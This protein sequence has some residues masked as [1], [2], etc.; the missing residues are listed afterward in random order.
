LLWGVLY[1][2]LAAG[3]IWAF[4][5]RAWFRKDA[6][7]VTSLAV[8]AAFC[9]GYAGLLQGAPLE[10]TGARE[11]LFWLAAGGALIA[12]LERLTRRDPFFVRALFVGV[13]LKFVLERQ[14]VN[15][16]QGANDSGHFPGLALAV[17]IGISGWYAVER[18]ARKSPGV[19]A[20]LTL[21]CLATGLALCSLWSSSG[22]YAQLAGT[23]AA[24]MGAACVL[25][26]L[27]PGTWFAGGGAGLAWA[28]LFGIGL[29]AHYY[30]QLSA[31]DALLLA[32]APFAGLLA[33][34][35]GL[36]Q[37]RPQRR[38]LLRT[39]LVLIP[40]AIACAR[41]HAVYAGLGAED[42]GSPESYGY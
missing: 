38:V 19:G 13:L 30:S 9:I 31:A 17:A 39:V 15:H 36:R 26:W 18:V 24:A 4:L 16:W 8:A 35:P 34:L 42:G 12:P 10:P 11:W 5:G 21:W 41:T 27:R 3:C 2:A 20:P 6:R 32:A 33:D 14:Y 23:I 22:L 40:I 1:P 37:Q 25:A 28:L 29:A 7:F